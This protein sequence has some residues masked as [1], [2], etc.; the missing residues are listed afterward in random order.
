MT[1][2]VCDVDGKGFQLTVDAV[3]VKEG[4]VLLTKRAIPPFEGK[5]V[6]PG[7]RVDM[8]ETLEETVHR[9]VEEETG[10]KIEIIKVS[11][12]YSAI[13]RDP[14]R[15]SVTIAFLCEALTEPKESTREASEIKWFT[16]GGLPE[17]GFDHR[18][19]VED[20]GVKV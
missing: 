11:G 20:A 4:K 2:I 19:I 17:M 16:F 15:R 18:K 5:W 8:N 13:D 9:E 10:M 1:D 6:L 7:G 3:I 14:R 12:A